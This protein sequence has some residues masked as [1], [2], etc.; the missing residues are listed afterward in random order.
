[1]SR[2]LHLRLRHERGSLGAARQAVAA[3]LEG[4]GVHDPSEWSLIVTELLTNAFEASVDAVAE[5]VLAL[6]DATLVLEV[7][8]EGPPFDDGVDFDMP[9]AESVRGRGLAITQALVDE[10]EIER[11]GSTTV[12]RCR[13]RLRN[14]VRRAQHA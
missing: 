9:G 8:N 10:L 4:V 6:D 13:R 11:I 14:G 3:W 2:P 7:C 12:V 5:L 1:M